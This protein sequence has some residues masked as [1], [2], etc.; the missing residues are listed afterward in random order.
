MTLSPNRCRLLMRIAV[1]GQA[2]SGTTALFSSVLQGLA[3]KVD[4]IFEPHQ[5][6]HL[7]G[8]YSVKPG[9]DHTLAKILIGQIHQFGIDTSRIE[10]AILI[11]RDPRDNLVSR[12]L[13]RANLFQKQNDSQSF[14][15]FLK[16]IK[17]KVEKPDAISVKY[18]FEE[19]ATLLGRNASF[20]I[21]FGLKKSCL[22]T[23]DFAKTSAELFIVKY[24]NYIDGHI[25][26]LVDYLGFNINCNVTVSE[27]LKRVERSKSYGEWKNWFT[28]ED[29]AFFKPI[30]HDYINFFGYENDYS[31]FSRKPINRI[32]SVDYIQQFAP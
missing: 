22:N 11:V 26:D 3:G 5:K 14:N 27:K 25:N 18:L 8:V 17:L 4:T 30:F 21:G 23:V 12:L 1:I 9:Y 24:E 28:D 16:L 15:K 7:E 19:T 6:Q 32:T 2:K 20:G 10:K 29:I 13:Y 31:L